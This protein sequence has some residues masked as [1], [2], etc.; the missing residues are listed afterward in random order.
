[1]IL[2]IHAAGSAEVPDH[3]TRL[4]DLLQWSMTTQVDD[5]QLRDILFF[6]LSELF[7]QPNCLLDIAAMRHVLTLRCQSAADW[8]VQAALQPLID[9]CR[10]F[11]FE[12][13]VRTEAQLQQLIRPCFESQL[14]YPCA[15]ENY[16]DVTIRVLG[17]N[18]NG[19]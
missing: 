9:L 10:D 3:K 4:D 14:I 6:H 12:I 2:R 15:R 11:P 13:Y 17:K 16:P 19:D 7:A 1:M 18:G 5:A 8:R